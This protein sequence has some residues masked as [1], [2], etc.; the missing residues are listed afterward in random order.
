MK[1]SNEKVNPVENTLRNKVSYLF[2][3]LLIVT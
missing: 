2:I 1:N 3:Y